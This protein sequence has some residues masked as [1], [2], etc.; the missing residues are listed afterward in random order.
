MVKRKPG[1][2]KELLGDTIIANFADL[3]VKDASLSE[4]IF[5]QLETELFK[6][7]FEMK[8]SRI[9]DN[10]SIVKRKGI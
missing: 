1:A 3:L 9:T 5:L 7:G 8:V 2:R 6:L 4:D 10:I